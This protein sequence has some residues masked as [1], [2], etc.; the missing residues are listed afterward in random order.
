MVE[1]VPVERVAGQSALIALDERQVARLRK[2]IEHAFLEAHTAVAPVRDLELGELGLEEVSSA[3][4]VAAVSFQ[5][6]LV[7]HGDCDTQIR[8]L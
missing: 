4:A 3:V 2:R 6:R 7:C 1:E 8:F 5:V